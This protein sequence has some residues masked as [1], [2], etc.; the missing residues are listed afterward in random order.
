LTS[1]KSTQVAGIDI[2]LAAL[3]QEKIERAAQYGSTLSAPTRG[4]VATV[5][6]EAGQCRVLP[7]QSWPEA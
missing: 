3:D 1:T 4:V 7:A 6:V 5:L 2:Q